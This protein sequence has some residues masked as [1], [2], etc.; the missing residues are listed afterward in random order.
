LAVITIILFYNRDYRMKELFERKKE[1]KYA[2][3]TLI[4]E[5]VIGKG[6]VKYYYPVCRIWENN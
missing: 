5:F 2:F 6:T 4:F 1:F 3:W